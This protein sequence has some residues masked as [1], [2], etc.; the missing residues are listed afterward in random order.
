ME[1]VDN[2]AK[3]T[4]PGFINHVFNF[5][6]E[7]KNDLLNIG[8]YLLLALVPMALYN[9]LVDSLIPEPDESKGNLEILAEVVGQFALVLSGIFLIHRLIT[10]VPTYSGRA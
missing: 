3:N 5:D 1:D 4:K 9:H 8:Q 6:T 2:S 7:T 10:Y